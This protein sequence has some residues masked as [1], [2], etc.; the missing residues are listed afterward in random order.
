MRDAPYSGLKWE[1]LVLSCDWAI[2]STWICLIVEMLQSTGNL[3]WVYFC[4]MMKK[5]FF[6]FVGNN[7]GSFGNGWNKIYII[8]S[9]GK[10]RES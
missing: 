1:F 8:F 4:I 7:A 6:Y 3:K 5:I 10:K 2:S 9:V